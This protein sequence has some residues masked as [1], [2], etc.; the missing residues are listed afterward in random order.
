[1]L[2]ATNTDQDNDSST[3]G[4]I[5]SKDNELPALDNSMVRRSA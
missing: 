5:D 2:I 1:M 4:S 3:D